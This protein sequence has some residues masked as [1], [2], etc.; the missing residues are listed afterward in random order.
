[1]TKETIMDKLIKRFY[2]ISG[3][4]DEY[5]RAEI[6]RIGNNCFVVLIIYLLLSSLV[7]LIFYMR[8]PEATFFALIFMNFGF[9]IY[10]LFMY[11]LIKVAK[12]NLTE[13]T[14]PANKIKDAKRQAARRGL[15]AGFEF[16]VLMYGINILTSWGMKDPLSPEIFSLKR[17]VLYIIAGVFFG[18]MTWLIC[19]ARI[20]KIK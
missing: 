2:G 13:N 14:V 4:L 18:L 19:L 8:F 7:A 15:L 17:I 9:L 3:P 1:M 16:S 6:N 12:L 20:K 10:G 5:R 11:F